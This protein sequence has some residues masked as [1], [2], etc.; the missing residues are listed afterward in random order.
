MAMAVFGRQLSPSAA[1][2]TEFLA[3]VPRAPPRPATRR[4][5]WMETDIETKGAG[6]ARQRARDCGAV[7][8][9]QEAVFK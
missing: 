3:A 2:C 4:R 7:S 1:Q 6:L 9:C 5:R 8:F